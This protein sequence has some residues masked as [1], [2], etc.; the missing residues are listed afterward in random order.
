[1]ILGKCEELG[2]W[3]SWINLTLENANYELITNITEAGYSIVIVNKAYA[4]RTLI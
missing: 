4:F 2:S 3:C 1:M